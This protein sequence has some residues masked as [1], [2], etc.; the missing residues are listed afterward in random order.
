MGFNV[1]GSG[2]VENNKQKTEPAFSVGLTRDVNKKAGKIII[3]ERKQKLKVFKYN[4][5]NMLQ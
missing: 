2:I 3:S 5:F 4:I 1:T